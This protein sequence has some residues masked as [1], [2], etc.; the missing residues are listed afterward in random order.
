MFGFRMVGSGLSNMQRSKAQEDRYGK[1]GRGV[2]KKHLTSFSGGY[3]LSRDKTSY[4]SSRY[5]LGDKC[6]PPESYD[7]STYTRENNKIGAKSTFSSP[8]TLGYNR[9]KEAMG[10]ENDG[11]ANMCPFAV[12]E[13]GV[14]RRTLSPDPVMI[15]TLAV[16]KC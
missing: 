11:K 1:A 4:Y 3:E 8:E 14:K 5:Q 15:H 10:S 2:L 16:N 13:T 9:P 12:K 6:F 7:V